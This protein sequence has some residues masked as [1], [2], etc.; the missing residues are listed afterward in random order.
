[1]V[2]LEHHLQEL[3]LLEEQV[4]E[5]LVVE[6]DLLKLVYLVLE[7]VVMKLTVDL[8]VAVKFNIDF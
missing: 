6:V 1:V 3:V 2:E 7:V 4:L 8:A 5:D